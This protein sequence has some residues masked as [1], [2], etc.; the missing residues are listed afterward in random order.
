MPVS[1]PTRSGC[2]EKSIQI[3]NVYKKENMSNLNKCQKLALDGIRHGP[4]EATSFYLVH[5]VSLLEL[6]SSLEST[7][8]QL[9][10][11]KLTRSEDI[12]FRVY[13]ET[14]FEGDNEG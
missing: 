13:K 4:C 10:Q 3:T 11:K 5:L 8:L 6:Q 9:G 14:V 12:Y 7:T 1:Y 2:R